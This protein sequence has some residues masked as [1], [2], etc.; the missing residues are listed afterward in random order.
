MPVS[1]GLSIGLTVAG[2]GTGLASG[3]MTIG[4]I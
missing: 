3:G 1:G 2:A 4:T